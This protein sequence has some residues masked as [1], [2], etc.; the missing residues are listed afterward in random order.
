MGRVDFNQVVVHL[1]ND[2]LIICDAKVLRIIEKE[3][4]LEKGISIDSY[5]MRFHTNLK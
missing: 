4:A 5:I 3:V 1:S 2:M